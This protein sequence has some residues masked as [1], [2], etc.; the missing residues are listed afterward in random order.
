MSTG[1]NIENI[2]DNL[3]IKEY[4][5][6]NDIDTHIEGITFEPVNN[7]NYQSLILNRKEDKDEDDDEDDE[8]EM[9]KAEVL[10][11]RVNINDILK[12]SSITQFFFGGVTVIGLFIVFQLIKKSK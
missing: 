9:H 8:D 4:V 11:N 7:G 2:F 10:K 12:T 6:D 1:Y 5:L 3:G